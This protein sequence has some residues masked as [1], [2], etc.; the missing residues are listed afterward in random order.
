MICVGIDI[1]ASGVKL[2][3]IQPSGSK[4]YSLTRFQEFPLSADPMKDKKIETLDILRQIAGAYD[5]DQ[6]KFI[7]AVHQSHVALRFRNFPFKERFKIMRSIAFELEDDV[8]F[9]QEDAVF[10]A[11]I[12]R[13]VENSADVIAS[14]CPH[15][16][17]KDVVDLAREA[18]LDPELVTV[19]GLALGNYFENIFEAPPVQ[20]GLGPTPE[21]RPAE[22]I[23]DIGHSRSLLVIH[24][25]GSLV[26]SRNIDWGGKQLAESVAAKYGLHYLEALK[27]LQKKAFILLSSEGATRD[28]IVFSDLLKSA[29]EP[30]AQEVRFTLLEMATSR[31]LRFTKAHITGGVSQVKNLGA[32]L[33]QKWEIPV[34]RFQ[35][36]KLIP[37]IALETTPQLD[38]MSAVS[39]A[40]AMEGL[41]RARNPATDLMKGEFAQQGETLKVFMDKWGYAAQLLGAAFF[42]LLVYGFMREM[43]ATDMAEKALDTLK[44]QAAII[45]D[46]KGRQATPT[47]VRRFVRQKKEEINARK[48]AV[49]VKQLNSALDVLAFVHQAAPGP[50][51]MLV[52]LRRVTVDNELME[53]HGEVSTPDAVARLRQTLENVALDGKVEP[54]SPAITA[55][56]GKQ[57]FGFRLK[58]DRKR[59]G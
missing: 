32:F 56:P 40:I 39:I 57:A 51:Q 50:K 13:Y 6:T 53:L 2:A 4:S 31:N 41:R 38:A 21:A 35:H 23:L 7:L 18:G 10:D 29:F 42:L 52:E 28:Q 25:E 20:A 11:K 48:L 37:Q 12:A 36:L 17:I 54:I 47:A 43:F 14:A 1:G 8:P 45:A 34:N 15:I 58:V 26:H 59:G 19:D 33:T 49:G 5:P 3:E 44:S 22:I 30:L 9:S 24:S 46:L 16:Y 55:M 27:E